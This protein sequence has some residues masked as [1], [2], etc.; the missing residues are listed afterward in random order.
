MSTLRAIFWSSLGKKYVTGITGLLLVL[1]I[2]IH[3]I[4]NLTLLIG[5]VAFNQYAHFLE[6]LF[7]GYFVVVF[8]IGLIVVFILHIVYGVAVTLF[9]KPRARPVKYA[10]LRNAGGASQKTISS[11]SMIITGLVLLA[12]VVWHVWQFKFGERGIFLSDGHKLGDLYGVV[13]AAF[14]TPLIMIAYVAVMILLGVHLRHG[15]WSAFQSLGWNSE[16]WLGFLTGLSLVFAVVWAVG[17]LVLPLYVYFFVEPS[18]AQVVAAG[19][20]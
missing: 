20:L 19:G 17:F 1:Y 6:S 9:D 7:F 10:H 11:R 5:P 15:F 3:L 13:V 4:G 8:E 14:K 2:I 12:F 16:K 18:A